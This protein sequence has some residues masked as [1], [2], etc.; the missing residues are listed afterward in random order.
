M[1]DAC[2]ELEGMNPSQKACLANEL[3]ILCY[4]ALADSK[5]GVVYIDLPGKFP[6]RSVWNMRYVFICKIYEANAILVRLM[7]HTRH[8]LMVS[9]YANIYKYLEQRGFKPKLN[10]TDKKFSKPVKKYVK[11]KHIK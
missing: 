11:T 4:A 7:T 3:N 8:E 6:I 5:T 9:T 1:K 2:L 10:I